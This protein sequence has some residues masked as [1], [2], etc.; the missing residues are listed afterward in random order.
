MNKN[1]SGMWHNF[2]ATGK[3]SDYLLYKGYGGTFSSVNGGRDPDPGEDEDADQSGG[4]YRQ[5]PRYR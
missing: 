2:E 4:D 1:K 5:A 3:I